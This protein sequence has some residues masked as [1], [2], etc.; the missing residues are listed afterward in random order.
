MYIYSTIGLSHFENEEYALW[1]GLWGISLIRMKSTHCPW[2]FSRTIHAS[3]DKSICIIVYIVL[4]GSHA[5][6]TKIIHCVLC[7]GSFTVFSA[8]LLMICMSPSCDPQPVQPVKPLFHDICTGRTS[9]FKPFMGR[10]C[11]QY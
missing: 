6:R 4:F 2:R 9:R 1:F 11:G 3:Y 10:I 7:F 5:L 8:V